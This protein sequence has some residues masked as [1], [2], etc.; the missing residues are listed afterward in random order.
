M[1][2]SHLYPRICSSCLCNNGNLL[3]IN[4]G[5]PL[6][7]TFTVVT[8]NQ[9]CPFGEIGRFGRRLVHHLPHHL[10]KKRLVSNPSINQPTNGKR[11]CLREPVFSLFAEKNDGN[12]KNEINGISAGDNK[13]Q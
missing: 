10:S 4:G 2:N 5:Y 3:V 13:Y 9:Q 7:M 11:T 12:A 6:V 1:I 8:C